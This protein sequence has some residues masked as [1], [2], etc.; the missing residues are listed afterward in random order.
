MMLDRRLEFNLLTHIIIDRSL[1]KYYKYHNSKPHPRMFPVT[2][3]FS[4]S[5]PLL[6]SSLLHPQGSREEPDICLLDITITK[7]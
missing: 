7:G 5:S 4:V 6:N 1:I 3:E 2:A